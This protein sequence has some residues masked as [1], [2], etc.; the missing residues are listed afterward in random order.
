MKPSRMAYIIVGL[1][2]LLLGGTSALV[3]PIEVPVTLN[4]A[5][6]SL[7]PLSSF[8][9]G[10]ILLASMVVDEQKLPAGLKKDQ[11]VRVLD[12]NTI[13]LKKNGVVTLA[14][15]RMPSPGASG[16]QFPDCLSYIPA[17]KLRQLVPPNSDVL[18]KV[19][20]TTF[21]GKSAQAVIFKSED[22]VLIN[23]ELVR[24]GF[25]KVQRILSPDLKEY[26]DMDAMQN[27]EA[28]AKEEGTGI[29][30][31]CDMEES[32]GFEAQ[33]EPLEL[34]VETQWGD[35]GGKRVIRQKDTEQYTPKNP[36]DIKG[37]LIPNLRVRVWPRT[38]TDIPNAATMM[39]RMFG[40]HHVRRCAS[41]V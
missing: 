37:T 24:T 31:R 32:S 18:V 8:I 13:K 20:S 40:L 16:F 38:V 41:V 39:L 2:A 22:A 36:G 34:T 4:I 7:S 29:Y 35:D 14:G 21:A 12:A 25:G 23:Q 17:Y 6:G 27:L 10:T 1:T 11:V 9:D 5:P 3:I 30:R 33:F 26:L 28:R 19:G 15:V